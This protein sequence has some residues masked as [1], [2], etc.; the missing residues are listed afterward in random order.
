MTILSE[1]IFKYVVNENIWGTQG[2]MHIPISF[3]DE[4]VSKKYIQGRNG[5][6]PR[7]N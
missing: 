6:V 7:C 5:P 1:E 2:N 4:K 3:V